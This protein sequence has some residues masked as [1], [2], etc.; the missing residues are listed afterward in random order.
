MMAQSLKKLQNRTGGKLSPQNLAKTMD[1]SEKY[2]PSSKGDAQTLNEIRELYADRDAV[3]GSMP[4]PAGIKQGAAIIGNSLAGK[5]LNV[6]VD[7]LSER[8]G[9]ERT[10]TRLYE[11][12][13]SKCQLKGELPG[14][15]SVRELQ[16]IRNEELEHFHLIKRTIEELGG[17]PTVVTPCA[18]TSAV[19]SE[20][21]CKVITDPRTTMLQSLEAILIAEL[22]GNEGCAMLSDR[23][24][25]PGWNKL[26][27]LSEDAA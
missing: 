5:D 9:F 1:A 3:V 11:G 13:I 15:P 26:A 16:H 21:I 19:A 27:G 7:K 8:L 20:G 23:C 22:R 10:G 25:E 12:L 17:D 4:P 2:G 6:L 14:G 24:D 18:N